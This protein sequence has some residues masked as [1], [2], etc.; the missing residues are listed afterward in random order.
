[1]PHLLV[2]G[3]GPIGSELTQAFRRLGS[4]VTVVDIAPT[5]LPRE[6]RDLAQVVHRQLAGEGVRYHLGVQ[7]VSVEGRP[8]DVR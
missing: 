8:G 5:V 2:I 3:S 6:D 4:E 1:M 7:I